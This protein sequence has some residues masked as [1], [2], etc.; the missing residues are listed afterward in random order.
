MTLPWRAVA[1]SIW[2]VVSE[3]ADLRCWRTLPQTYQ[4]SRIYLPEG[5]YPCR[6][7]LVG[8]G[9]YDLGTVVVEAGKH[10]MINARS[11]E[12][13]LYWHL[14]AVPYDGVESS[15]QSPDSV[16][17]DLTQEDQEE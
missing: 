7:D 12:R 10:R 14:P 8:G 13:K 1:T 17:V 6:I 2:N 3:Q 4:V 11:L 9:S 15:S 16:N 5:T